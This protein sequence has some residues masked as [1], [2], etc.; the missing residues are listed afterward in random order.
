[1]AK[2]TTKK[3][4]VK[5]ADKLTNPFS[6]KTDIVFCGNRSGMTAQYIEMLKEQ[7]LQL[8][9][10]DKTTSVHIPVTICPTRNSA[11]NLC[12]GLKRL[13]KSNKATEKIYISSKS[14]TD[15]KKT[16]LGSRVWRLA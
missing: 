7:V 5:T 10:G 12:L 15:D 2:T 16:Y 8:K 1:M 6:I 3:V 14:I 13:L 11:S 9:P 4:A